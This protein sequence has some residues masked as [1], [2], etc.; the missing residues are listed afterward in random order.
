MDDDPNALPAETTDAP[1]A[2]VIE[3]VAQ[4]LQADDSPAVTG[5]APHKSTEASEPV[6]PQRSR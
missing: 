6:L 2:A 1:A 5:F 3:R 4:A